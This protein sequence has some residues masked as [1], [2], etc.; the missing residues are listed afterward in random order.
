MK[1]PDTFDGSDPHNF[2]SWKVVFTSW[3]NFCEPKFQKILEKI[4]EMADMP[5]MSGY[6]TEEQGLS[7]L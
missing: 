4:E 6:S 1:D 5:T 3:L 7:K 2:M